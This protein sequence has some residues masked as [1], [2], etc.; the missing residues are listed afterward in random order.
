M[1]H[2]ADMKPLKNEAIKAR[3]DGRT[4]AQLFQLAMARELDVSDLIRE[5]VRELLNRQP[6]PALPAHGR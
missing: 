3:V 4:K 5:A 2:I 6:L 1:R